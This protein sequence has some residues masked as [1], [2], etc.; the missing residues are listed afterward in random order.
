[1]ELWKASF[2]PS[3]LQF[4]HEWILLDAKKG[5]ENSLLF[6]CTLSEI[7]SHLTQSY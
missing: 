1:M 3:A 7:S 6:P 4:N 5:T 2:N